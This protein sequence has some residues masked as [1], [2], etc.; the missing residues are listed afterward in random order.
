M[1]ENFPFCI[2]KG[3]RLKFL[4]FNM[5]L[6]MKTVFILANSADPDDMPHYVAFHLDLHCLST[7]WFTGTKN[8]KG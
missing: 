8:E 4:N 2:L 1:H 7:Y 5:F 3:N 6:S